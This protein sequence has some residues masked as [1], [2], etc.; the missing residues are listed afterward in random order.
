MV[1]DRNLAVACRSLASSAETYR[2]LTSFEEAIR[3]KMRMDH[4]NLTS[5]GEPICREMRMDQRT[6][7]RNPMLGE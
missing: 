6:A 7:N 2:N 1:E 3:M 4:R 5:L